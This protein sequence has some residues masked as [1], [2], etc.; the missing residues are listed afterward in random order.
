MLGHNNYHGMIRK[1]IIVFGSLFDDIALYRKNKAGQVVQT[2]AV[3]IAYGPKEKWLSRVSQDPT[4]NK[5]IDVTLPRIG[6]EMMSLTYDPQRKLSSTQQNVRAIPDVD[7]ALLSQFVPVPYNLD[8]TLSIFTR[9]AEDGAMIIEQ[10]LPY[11]TPDFT[12]SVNAIPEMDIKMDIPIILTGVTTQDVYDGDFETRR[13]LTWD[14]N[15]TIKGYMY[16]PVKKTGVIKRV[17]ADANIVPGSDPVV[18]SD[19]GT[20]A[21]V[22]RIVTQPGLTTAGEPTTSIPASI[23]YTQV[24]VNDPYGFAQNINLYTD[25][26]K[27]DPVTGKD[28]TITP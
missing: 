28:V 16:G 26:K 14:L 4:L 15:F 1:Y 19:I 8:M 6:F 18:Q 3:P 5:Y 27:Y 9:N 12:V 25:G 21:R 17:I 20:T 13:S 11:F 22:D 2:I 24:N 23:P 7:N 10:I